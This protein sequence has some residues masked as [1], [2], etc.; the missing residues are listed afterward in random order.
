MAFCQCVNYGYPLGGKLMREFVE[1]RSTHS[2]CS[3]VKSLLYGGQIV[4]LFKRN[5]EKGAD[6]V[7]SQL[8]ALLRCCVIRQGFRIPV[9]KFFYGLG[10]LDVVDIGSFPVYN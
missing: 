2:L 7:I 8:K 4:Q 3:S 9:P 6:Y 1:N 5:P 10:S